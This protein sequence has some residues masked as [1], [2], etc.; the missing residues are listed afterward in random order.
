MYCPYGQASSLESFVLGDMT[1]KTCDGKKAAKDISG[2]DSNCDVT[3]NEF[4]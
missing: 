2:Y 1:G 4:V 3:T